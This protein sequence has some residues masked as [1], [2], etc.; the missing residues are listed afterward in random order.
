MTAKTLRIF[1]YALCTVSLFLAFERAAEMYITVDEAITYTDH[2]RPR[3][4]GVFDFSAA[5]N[6]LLNTVLA[7]ALTTFAPYNELALRIPSLAIGGWFFLAYIPNRFQNWSERLLFASICLFPYYISEYWSL[8]R[9]YFMSTCFSAAALIEISASF[10][11]DSSNSSISALARARVFG[12]LA[13]LASFVMLPFAITTGIATVVLTKYKAFSASTQQCLSNWSSWF[14]FGSCAISAFAIHSFKAAGEAL[15]YT[16]TFSF[17]APIDAVVGSLVTGSWISVL[18][19]K[20][21][22]IT[23]VVLCLVRNE[24]RSRVL[25]SIVVI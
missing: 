24:S 2:V 20:A 7:K 1:Y 4:S 11:T 15:S 16:S 9:G 21:L 13:T 3:L 18:L 5:N 6:H 23:S 22:A 12:S 8:S 25:V 10:S 14:L 19:F 17:V